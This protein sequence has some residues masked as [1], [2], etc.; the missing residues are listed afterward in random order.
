MS[1]NALVTDRTEAGRALAERLVRMSLAAPVV[2]LA[3]PRGGVPIGAEVARALNAPLDLLLVRKIG[4]PYQRELA[5]AAV[6]DG[7][8]LAAATVS[9]TPAHF[10]PHKTLTVS[11]EGVIGFYLAEGARHSL[12]QSIPSYF[13]RNGLCYALTRGAL[14]DRGHI[15]EEDCAAVVIDRHVVNIDEPFELELAEFL[16]RR[17]AAGRA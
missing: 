1:L 13:H 12:R 5:V 4:A 3:L 15:L 16:L 14:V 8:H 2:V 6:V 11:P 7:G 9:R 10:T 17:E